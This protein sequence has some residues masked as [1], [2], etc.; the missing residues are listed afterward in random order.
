MTVTEQQRW[1]EHWVIVI[2]K[3][4]CLDLWQPF[5]ATFK[6]VS[7]FLL[8]VLNSFGHMGFMYSSN[9]LPPPPPMFPKQKDFGCRTQ[10][11]PLMV[12]SLG[13]WPCTRTPAFV[14]HINHIDSKYQSPD[15]A[16]GPLFQ[17][18]WAWVAAWEEQES[19]PQSVEEF[20]RQL[21]C[22]WLWHWL[23]STAM[24]KARSNAEQCPPVTHHI[25]IRQE[26]GVTQAG[27]TNE[28][29]LQYSQLG[30]QQDS[31]SSLCPLHRVLLSWRC[32]NRYSGVCANFFLICELS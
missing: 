22:K 8:F 12:D 18:T 32:G 16:N 4:L 2:F 24:S 31:W 19:L 21:L 15:P 27:G 17:L 28:T 26:S 23:Q 29:F 14:L 30:K 10:W 25:H 3:S 6:F 9:P 13:G 11:V 1:T 20:S 5:C 7:H